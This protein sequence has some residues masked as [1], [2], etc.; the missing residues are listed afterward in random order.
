MMLL[1]SRQRGFTLIEVLIASSIA[2]AAMG[3]LLGLFAT[4]LDRMSRIEVH[5][6]QLIAEKEVVGRM[7]LI[8]PAEWRT[9]TGRV[10]KWKFTW[11]TEAL[12]EFEPTTDYF[13]SDAPPRNVALFL[14]KVNMVYVEGKTVDFQLKK[15]GW[16][17]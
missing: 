8:N 16:L 14:I 6:Q 10:G 11:E 9:G 1:P 4:S 3:L 13:S 2:V 17:K 7:S 12:S 15:L 5:S